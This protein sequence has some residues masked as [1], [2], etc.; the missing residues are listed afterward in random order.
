LFYTS[1]N[2]K[3]IKDLNIKLPSLKLVHERAGRTLE[4]IG[5]GKDFVRRISAAQQLREKMDNGTT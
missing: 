4:A 3:C 2:S 5:T 1:I